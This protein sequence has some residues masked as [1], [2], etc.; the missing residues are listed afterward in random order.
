MERNSVLC[1]KCRRLISID[2]P[3]CPYCGLKKPGAPWKTALWGRIHQ[4]AFDPVKGLIYTNVLFYILSLLLNPSSMGVS[5][6]PLQLLSPS[7]SSLFILGATGTWPIMQFGRWWTLVTASFLHG[8]IIHLVFNMMALSQLAPF[9][10]TEYGFYRFFVIYILS[11]VVGFFL[12]CLAGVPLTIGASAGICG[13]I[14]AILYFGKSRGGFY[15]ENI[16]RQA[17]GWVVGLVLFGLILP[18]IN[19][20]AHIGGIFGGIAAGFLLGY[21]ERSQESG[22]HRWAGGLT[23]LA[24]G[25]LLLIDILQAFYTILIHA[26]HLR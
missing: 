14:G 20:W 18:G 22:F 12:S 8:G 3:V 1:P 25:G 7:D 9:V 26:A 24:T 10:I 23:L 17:M 19:N 2:E 6:N 16:F 11:G 4:G 13:L 5:V 21:E 15:G